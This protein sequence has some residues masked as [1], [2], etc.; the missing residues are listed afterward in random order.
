MK[1]SE[2]AVS[3]YKVLINRAG[4]YSLRDFSTVLSSF[5]Y[6]LETHPPEADSNNRDCYRFNSLR[7]VTEKSLKLLNPALF[8]I[9]SVI[10]SPDKSRGEA[11]S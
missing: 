8:I 4:F 7:T 3:R 5:R 2:T 11:I 10:A 6:S 1:N 9:F